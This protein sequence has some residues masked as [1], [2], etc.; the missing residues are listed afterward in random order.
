MKRKLD[1]PLKLRGNHEQMSENVKVLDS[2][3][4]SIDVLK[5]N[6][7]GKAIKL[8]EEDKKV[9]LGRIK[10]IGIVDHEDWW[11]TSGEQ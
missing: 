7:I 11:T 1:V 2:T 8:L 4:D 9:V 3:E 10:L 5:N 6:D